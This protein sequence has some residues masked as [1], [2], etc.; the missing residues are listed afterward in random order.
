MSLLFDLKPQIIISPTTLIQTVAEFEET[1]TNHLGF[2]KFLFQY[3]CQHL[4]L[5]N[6]HLSTELAFNFYV[7]KRIS[8]LLEVP[9]ETNSAR[10]N[11]YNKLIQNTSLLANYNFTTILTEIN[12]EIEIHTQQRYPII[13]ANKGKGKLQTPVVTPQRIQPPIW[14]KTRVEL[15][16]NPSYYYTPRSAINI[17]SI[18]TSTSNITSTF[19]QFSFQIIAINSLS[20]VQRQQPPLQLQVQ[21][22]LQA[23]QQLNLNQMAYAPITKLK[24]FTGEENNTQVWLNN[25]EKAIAVN[26]WDDTRAMQ[27]IPYFLQDTADLWYQNL[28]NKPQDFNHQLVGNTFTT[29]KQGE[30]EAVT[31]YLRHFHKNLHQIQTI[32][33]DYFT[34]PQILNQFIKGLCSSILQQVHPIHL[35]D[36]Q[37]AVTNARDFE[38]AELKANHAQAINL[39]INGSSELDSKLKQFSNSINQKLEEYLADNYTIYQISHIHHPPPINNGNRKC[40]FATTVIKDRKPTIR[41]LILKSQLLVSN[42][43]LLTQSNIIL[44]KLHIYNAAANL[45]TTNLLANNTHHLSLAVPTHL[46]TA[47]LSN[48]STPTNTGTATKLISK[49]NPKAETDT[50]KLE[51]DDSNPLTNLQFINATIRISTIEFGHQ[52]YPKSKCSTIFKSS[53]YLRRPTIT[54]NKS[55]VVIFP[56]EL[57]ETLVT[58]LF[59]GAT[60]KKKPITAMYTNATVNDQLGHRVDQTASARIIMANGATKTPIGKIDDFSFEVNDIITSIKVLPM[61]Y[62]IEPLRN[63]NSAKMT[64]THKYQQSVVTSN[65]ATTNQVRGGQGKTNVRSILTWETD[66]N[67][68]EPPSWE[69]KK[70]NKRKRKKKE[71]ETTPISTATYNT[72]THTILQ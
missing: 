43:E 9:V 32:Q 49:W 44:T 57:E 66:N 58:P 25:V 40:V 38:A 21:L 48:L 17:L 50:T 5:T 1:E 35:A 51:I 65:P 60:L 29:I 13:Y 45:S 4:G 22:P 23:P 14:K 69:W 28:A 62:L 24:K 47:A 6:N 59:S 55:L 39:V 71:K 2:A 34:V 68:D 26:G 42:S 27:A 18:D 16:T 12:K 63:C 19:G 53:G 54:N 8:Y 46:S 56:F 11:F 52:V 31:T 33:A 41:K 37:A 70:T 10:E 30:N 15:P 3:Y 72:N 36:L 64:N 61:P 67:Q 20:V 7:N